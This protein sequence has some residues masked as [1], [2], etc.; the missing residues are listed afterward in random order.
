MQ[1]TSPW[2]ERKFNFETISGTFPFIIDRLDG[3]VL[4][5]RTKVTGLSS[6]ILTAEKEDNW[7]IQK[8]IGHL[9]DLE[10]LW[11]N[12]IKDILNGEE[13][14]REA[15]LTNAKTHNANHNDRDISDLIADFEIERSKLIRLCK[16]VESDAERLTSLHPRLN[17]PMKIIDLCYFVAEHDDH[18]LATVNYL[19]E[20]LTN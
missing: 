14:L 15:D 2:F 20:N 5:I 8:N 1:P 6:E 13:Y 19:L 17:K 9:L 7:S 16:D 18:H 4:S 3:T 10:P 12:R 11:L